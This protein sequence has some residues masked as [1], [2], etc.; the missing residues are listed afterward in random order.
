MNLLLNS[1]SFIS[2][3]N[4]RQVN[5]MPT[6]TIEMKKKVPSPENFPVEFDIYSYLVY[7]VAIKEALQSQT[8][9]LLG[10]KTVVKARIKSDHYLISVGTCCQ[11]FHQ[12]IN[13]LVTEKAFK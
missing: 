11:E 4:H 6:I 1:V 5:D 10:K 12:E 2:L 9:K 13:E 3:I 7:K 8:C